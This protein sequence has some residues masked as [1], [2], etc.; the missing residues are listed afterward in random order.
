MFK[1]FNA[2]AHPLPNSLIFLDATPERVAMEI[3]MPVPE[4]ELVFGK[5]FSDHPAQ[6]AAK[7]GGKIREYLLQHIHAYGKDSLQWAVTVAGLKMDEGTY[8]GTNIKYWEV[9][10]TVI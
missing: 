2:A 9:F 1:G 4:L 7:Y 6:I 3:Q 10:A 8:V 5:G